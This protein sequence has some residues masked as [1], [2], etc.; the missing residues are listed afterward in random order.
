MP[1]NS[2][3][4]FVENGLVIVAG[5]H[6]G[7][8]LVARPSD[9]TLDDC[10]SELF[11]RPH[12]TETER[13][14]LVRGNLDRIAPIIMEKHRQGQ[15]KTERWRGSDIQVVDIDIDDLQRGPPWSFVPAGRE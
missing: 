12:S 1:Q 11:H 7:Q 10:I 9:V 13:L 6:E 14:T 5:D 2:W 8:R 3:D 4:A 15:S